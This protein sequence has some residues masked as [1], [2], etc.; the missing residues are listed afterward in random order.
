MALYPGIDIDI[1]IDQNQSILNTSSVFVYHS[2][3]IY[4]S[5]TTTN[6]DRSPESYSCTKVQG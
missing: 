3:E 4:D 2:F 5:M 6:C 1:D